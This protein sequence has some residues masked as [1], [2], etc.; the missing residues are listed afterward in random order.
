MKG[1]NSD[2]TDNTEKNSEWELELGMGSVLCGDARSIENLR[3]AC[4]NNGSTVM[5]VLNVC[6]AAINSNIYFRPLPIVP[7]PSYTELSKADIYPFCEEA[8]T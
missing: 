1:A 6:Y 4:R 8:S 3:P 7:V 5:L 2:V